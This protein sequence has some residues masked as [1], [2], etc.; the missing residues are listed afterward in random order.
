MKIIHNRSIFQ[1]IVIKVIILTLALALTSPTAL[2]QSPPEVTAVET[3]LLNEPTV[4]VIVA[5]HPELT[6]QTEQ[7]AQSQA[8]VMQSL[9]AGDFSLIHSYQNLPGLVGEVTPAGLEVLRQQ[10]EVAAI[11]LDLPVEAVDLAPSAIFIGADAVQR[12]FGLSGVGVNLAVLDTGVDTAHL[13]LATKIVGQH[14]FSRNKGC[15]PDNSL[16]SDNAQDENGHGTHVAGIIASQGQS[17]PRGIAADAGLVAVRVLS[18]SGSGF[19][20]DVLAGMDWVIA[21]QSQLNVRVMN[22][23]IGGG[24]YSGVCDQADANTILYAA[25]VQ[26]ARQVGITVF[27]AAGN[28]GQ[29]E[30]LMAPACVSGVIAVGNVYDI[31]L[32]RFTWPNCA[33]ESIVPDRVACSSNSSTE[34]DLLAPGVQVQSTNL[35]GGEG[36][37]SGTS[38]STPH[39]AAVAA[40]LLQANPTLTPDEL[41]TILKE[42]GLA[43]TDPRNGRVTPRLDAL[44][45]VTRVVIGEVDPISGTVLLQSRTDHSGTNIYLREEPCSPSLNGEPAAVTDAEG[46]FRVN[47]PAERQYQCLQ[48]VQ[49]GYLVGQK[50]LPEGELG[51]I[52]LPGGD[53]FQD[54]VI[55][56]LDLAFMAIHYRSDNPMADVNGDGQV[57]IFD[58]TIAASN[59]NQRGPVTNWE[60]TG[61]RR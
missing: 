25:A 54:G 29:T 36:F 41:G 57:D 1:W 39:A 3:V 26:A 10:P 33:D 24:S 21:H 51:T 16:E 59:Y 7:I 12:D 44:A 53:V 11:A 56:I 27:A 4:R 9:D 2:A 6:A 45:A 22:L 42:T 60:T 50:D 47:P 18:Q 40:L 28:G 8:G 5:L 34:L 14:C 19:S 61:R 52:T 35:G 37:K 48:A 23:S 46:H 58:L 31:A 20:S 15:L 13:D 32:E 55:N 17:S 38:L 49:L 43:V 30:T